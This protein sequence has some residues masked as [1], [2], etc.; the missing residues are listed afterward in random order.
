[1]LGSLITKVRKDKSI[2]KMALAK[3]TGVN[4]GHITHIEK[5]QRNPSHKTL[6]NICKSLDI[7]YQP[8]AYTYDRTISEDQERYKLINHISYNKVPVAEK[9]TDFVDC[10]SS[11]PNTSF[12][13]RIQ[14]DAME[15][16]L[17][18]GGIG[19]V[20]LNANLNNKDIGIFSYHG[21]ILIRRFIIR[22]DKLVLRS[23][24]KAYEDID[25]NEDTEFYIIGRI[26]NG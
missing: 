14:D 12:A 23:D 24:N 3:A 6:R 8:I 9:I 10:P 5:G 1:M 21:Q 26:V 16:H 7:P 17:K 20:E 15:P 2:T 22:R 11:A 18:K 4:I 25:I 19:F 13:L